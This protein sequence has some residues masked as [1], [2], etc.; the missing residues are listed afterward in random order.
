MR[1][2][3]PLLPARLIRRTKRFLADVVPETGPDAG[4]EVVAHCPNPG[5]MLGLAEPG[6]RVW[7]DRNDDPRKK[8]RYGWRLVEDAP[9]HFT[10]IDTGLANRVLRAAL[11]AGRVAGLAAYD[12]VLP[13]QRYGT[14]SRVDFLLRGPDLPDAYLEVKS[15]TLSRSPGLAAFPDSVT[16]R[17]AKHLEELARVAERGQRA[18]LFYLVQRS[19]CTRLAVAEDIDPAYAA[20]MQRAMDAGVE[21]MAHACHITPEGI[22]LSHPVTAMCGRTGNLR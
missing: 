20:A 4:R 17:G 8:L 19:D 11:E 9:G 15:V 13:E 21:V 16:A 1:F 2:P 14:A 12:R 10:G 3:T 5:S 18:I 22:E 6:T 7:I